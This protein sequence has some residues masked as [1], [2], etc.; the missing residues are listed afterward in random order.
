MK[1]LKKKWG[2]CSNI[3]LLIIFIVFAI[4]GSLSLFIADPILNF[5]GFEKHLI[6][7][8]VFWPVRI[9]I[10]FPIY[11]V[12]I[13]IIG[14]IFG[15]FDFFWNLEKKMLSKFGLVKRNKPK[16]SDNY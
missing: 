10:I 9:F 15:Q 13:L 4:T 5:F 12:L 1:E 16:K 2:I 6:N 14:T 3:Q 7:A 8:W 11:Q